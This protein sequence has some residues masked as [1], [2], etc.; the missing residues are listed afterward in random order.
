MTHKEPKAD[1]VSG[2]D[3]TFMPVDEI[4]KVN[5]LFYALFFKTMQRNV[6]TVQ[7]FAS[8]TRVKVMK[9]YKQKEKVRY[10]FL[11]QIFYN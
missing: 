2:C 10:L 5:V 6:L 9:S 7:S 8:L 4:E 3:F 1:S 11:H